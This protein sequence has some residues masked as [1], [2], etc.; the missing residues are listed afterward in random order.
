MLTSISTRSVDSK[1]Q[2]LAV[3]IIQLECSRAISITAGI[4]IP[5]PKSTQT[6]SVMQIIFSAPSH[7]HNSRIAPGNGMLLAS[8]DL[9]YRLSFPLLL[10]LHL[11]CLCY[12]QCEQCFIN[13]QSSEVYQMQPKTINL[14][15][16]IWPRITAIKQS[17]PLSRSTNRNMNH[18]SKI[19][20]NK[21]KSSVHYFCSR[22]IKRDKCDWMRISSEIIILMSKL[23]Q[24]HW[25]KK[26]HNKQLY[27]FK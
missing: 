16:P 13:H 19:N 20:V 24:I 1:T 15:V 11:I 25:Y 5:W 26:I 23:Q 12:F 18:E 9:V 10:S 8:K 3:Y 6:Y 27:H 22:R 2:K 4:G 21:Q 7:T 17:H 14:A